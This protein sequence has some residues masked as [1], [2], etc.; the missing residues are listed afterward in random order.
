[1]WSFFVF[2]R[3]SYLFQVQGLGETGDDT[4]D[5]GPE[6]LDF[7]DYFST[8]RDKAKS[9]KLYFDLSSTN[10][11]VERD[12]HVYKLLRLLLDKIIIGTFFVF[13]GL[14]ILF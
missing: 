4:V 10:E 8:K 9:P 3:S 14:E 6:D 11:D 12:S 5:L 7:I 1:M 2:D 13:H